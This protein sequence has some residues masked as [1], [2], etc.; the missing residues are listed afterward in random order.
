MDTRSTDLQQEY[1]KRFEG[2]DLYRDAV[3]RILCVDFFSEYISHNSVLLD[4]GA[5]WGEFSRNVQAGNKYAMDLNPD[6]GD[7][8]TGHSTFLHQDCSTTWPIED[9]VLDI[10]FT[11]NFLEHLPSKDLVEKTLHE[12]FR[13]LKPGGKI[14]CMGPNIKFVHGAY[15]DYWDHFIP[16]TEDSMAEVL[17]LKGFNVVEKVDRFLPY[18]MSGAGGTRAPLIAVKLY[19]KLPFAWRFFGKQFLV[20]AEKS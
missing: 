5:G 7:R 8:V 18:T 20:I 9:A 14:I 19:L 16:F 3:W 6:C 2:T 13:C 17:S 12:A 4:L 1:Q 10:I 11:S 15:W